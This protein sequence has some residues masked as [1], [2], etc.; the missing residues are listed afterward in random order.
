MEQKMNYLNKE[1]SALERAEDLVSR[2]SLEEKIAQMQCIMG[3]HQI[4]GKYPH[5]MG[6]VSMLMDGTTK[7]QVAER[8]RNMQ[9]EIMDQTPWRIPALFHIEALT[10]GVFP[11]ATSYPSAIAQAATWEPELIEKMADTTQKQ[12]MAVGIRQAL[13]PVMDISRDPRWGRQGET[14]GEDSAL[15]SAC[16]VAFVKGLQKDRTVAATAKHFLGYAFSEAG[17]NAAP[18]NVT[19]RKL[20]E[21][22]G[23]PFQAAITEADLKS[24]M[25]SYGTI[26]G[27]PVITSRKILHDLLRKEMGFEGVTVSDYTATMH[28]LTRFRM[29]QRM[30]ECAAMAICAGMDNEMPMPISY[31][32][33][34]IKQ[35]LAEGKIE[36]SMIDEA[37]LHILK[38]KFELGLFE[39]PYPLE[40]CMKEVFDRKEDEEDSLMM[41]KKSLVLLKNDGILPLDKEEIKKI[42]VIGPHGN[43]CRAMFGCYSY[44][45]LLEMMLGMTG[46]MVGVDTEA[47]R[48]DDKASELTNAV[49]NKN[50]D[51]FPGTKVAKELPG[52]DDALRNAFPNMHSLLEELK[53]SHSEIEFEYVKGFDIVGTD[54]S[55][56]EHGLEAAKSADLVFVTVGG[57]YGWGTPC[58]SGE[59]ADASQINLP[60]VQEQFLEKLA[61]L[62]VPYVAIHFDGRPVSSN[63]LDRSASA[64]IEAWSPGVHGAEAIKEVLFGDYNPGGKLPVTVARQSGQIPVYYAHESGTSYSDSMAG[65]AVGYMD[66]TA[67]PRYCFGYGLSYTSF[68]YSNLQIMKR[69][70]NADETVVISVDVEN[71]GDMMGDEVVQLYVSDIVASRVRPVR[72]LAEVMRITLS[73]LFGRKSYS[74]IFMQT[75]SIR[76]P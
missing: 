49:V 39:Q 65:E 38:V 25:N 30:E 66:E 7:E 4:A 60:G 33:D 46:G 71:T 70:L 24:V 32:E 2:M 48:K 44:G 61:L 72:E 51:T 34:G 64:I 5:G 26:D 62:N 53:T 10:G 20:R 58:T 35:M 43:S 6:E 16:S 41:A 69:E 19:G 47:A 23:R 54:D 56:F 13:S 31:T 27:K 14:Y 28:P 63:E 68:E 73:D 22:Y 3:E 8:I 55:D 37:V 29:T 9:K 15:V 40:D 67:Y 18:C 74:K 57:K 12:M 11:G 1:L 75:V 45:A 59:G 36:E 42:V 17:L 52:L 21:I 50:L 76:I